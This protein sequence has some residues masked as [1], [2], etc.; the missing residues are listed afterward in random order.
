MSN[1]LGDADANVLTIKKMLSSF[2][3]ALVY[4]CSVLKYIQCSS[5]DF[6]KFSSKAGMDCEQI[7]VKH[8]FQESMIVFRS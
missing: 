8:C 7:E 5:Q 4:C 2:D 6:L 3:R 1:T